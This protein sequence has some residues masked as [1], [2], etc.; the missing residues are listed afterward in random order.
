MFQSAG[1]LKM[2]SFYNK[3]DQTN[4]GHV[5]R[6]MFLKAFRKLD[7]PKEYVAII[8]DGIHRE[9]RDYVKLL[10]FLNWIERDL[11]SAAA[12]KNSPGEVKNLSYSMV[13]KIKNIFGKKGLLIKHKLKAHSTYE[14]SRIA[15]EA[16]RYRMEKRQH[17]A[18]LRLQKRLG[19]TK[20]FKV[21]PMK[22]LKTRSSIHSIHMEEGDHAAAERSRKKSMRNISDA[23]LA[24]VEKLQ[25]DASAA[26]DDHRNRIH[27]KRRA[28][29]VRLEE[30]LK[31]RRDEN[32]SNQ[33]MIN[34]AASK[35]ME[36]ETK[37]KLGNFALL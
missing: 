11:N 4:T 7:V 27:T 2:V 34:T 33:Q 32:L 30:R 24:K 23:C 35:T 26:A 13:S 25:S 22:Q 14:K 18:S 36:L 19:G 31:T 20:L 6:I 21:K 16:H 9:S 15:V 37:R 17:S 5:P 29:I 10:E 8:F 28:S 1:R 12:V 3:L